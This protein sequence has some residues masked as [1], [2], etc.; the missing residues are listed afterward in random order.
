MGTSGRH[1]T[2]NRFILRSVTE[3]VIREARVPIYGDTLKKM[4]RFI[5]ELSSK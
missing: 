3:R 5:L 4:V 2:L 1:N